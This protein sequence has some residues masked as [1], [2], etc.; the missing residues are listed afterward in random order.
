MGIQTVKETS[1]N[2]EGITWNEDSR[3]RLLV[4]K[5]RS[6]SYILRVKINRPLYYKF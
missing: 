5:K 3:K 2:E 1:R 4:I 6:L